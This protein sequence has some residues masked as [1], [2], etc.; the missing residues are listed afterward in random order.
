MTKSRSKPVSLQDLEALAN[1]GKDG[2]TYL[3][4][5]I[6]ATHAGP[7]WHGI[8]K[9]PRLGHIQLVGPSY[10]SPNDWYSIAGTLPRREAAELLVRSMWD[11]ERKKAGLFPYSAALRMLDT[12]EPVA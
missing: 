12:V 10:E 11:D 9:H 6:P 1:A 7:M 8:V 2:R 4:R 5:H 3:F